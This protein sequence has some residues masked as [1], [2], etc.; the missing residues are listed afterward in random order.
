MKLDFEFKS[1]DHIRYEDGERVSGPHGRARRLVKVEPNIRGQRGHTVTIFN[2]EGDHPVLSNNVQ[3]APKQMRVVEKTS[4]KI[5][6]RGFGRD[7][8]G[9]SFSDYGL[10]IL[11]KNGE[12]YKCIAHMHDKDAAIEYLE[13]TEQ[14]IEEE[15]IIEAKKEEYAGLMKRRKKLSAHI[16]DFTVGRIDLALCEELKDIGVL[17]IVEEYDL[18]KDSE[19]SHWMDIMGTWHDGTV[20]RMD[21]DL[22]SSKSY[23]HITQIDVR[24]VQTKEEYDGGLHIAK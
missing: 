19:W 14:N 24:L 5:V 17:E 23:P 2:V 16:Q 22:D 11:H 8:F 3:M 21:M 20:Y 13:Y 6:L 15:K 12:V 18:R 10:S 4:G 7:D 1:Y 9:H